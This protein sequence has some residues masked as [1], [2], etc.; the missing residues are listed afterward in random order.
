MRDEYFLPL[1]NND[2]R[3]GLLI[4]LVS[5]LDHWQETPVNGKLV[6]QTFTS[7]KH[8]TICLIKV[9]NLITQ[10]FG[11]DYVLASSCK[12]IVDNSGLN[13]MMAGDIITL[14]IVRY[15]KQHRLQLSSILKLFVD[16]NTS[17]TEKNSFRE[18]FLNHFLQN[19]ILQN[20]LPE[21]RTTEDRNF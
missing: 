8:S 5:W 3:F 15:L 16:M 14:L 6:K 20:L 10:S 12:M 21:Q 7:F 1:I 19:W 4:H 18:I 2:S 13:R 11:F 17:L 9:V